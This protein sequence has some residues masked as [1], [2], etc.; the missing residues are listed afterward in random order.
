MATMSDAA[1]RLPKVTVA[2][3]A[4]NRGDKLAF[5]L[6]KVAEF[7]YPE[8]RLE[9]V[10][11]DNASQ[12]GTAEMVRERFA[13]VNLIVNER[14]TG[15]AGWN[16]A[17]ER[18]TGEWFL[19]LDDDCYLERD[20]LRRA[21]DAARGVQA[22]LVSFTVAST[23][24]GQAFTDLSRTGLL[25]FWGCSVLISRRALD[26]VGGF[27]D[28]L[29]VHAHEAEWAIRF[30][31]AGLRHLHMPEI[32]AVHM[33]ALPQLVASVRTLAIRNLAYT[34][35][36]HLQ[37]RDALVALAGL[38][39]NAAIETLRQPGLWPSLISVWQGFA[40][41]WAVRRPVRPAVSRLYR[42]NVLEF[43]FGL[44]L[45]PRLRHVAVHRGAPGTEFFNVY[46]NARSRLYP[47]ES[48]ALRVPR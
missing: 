8:D 15:I 22:D 35:A 29:F 3:L 23:E 28:W 25:A 10:V 39:S 37:P 33:K 48:A 18:G 45:R 27:D 9:V 36:K 24:P 11:V 21:V 7:D 13:H 1:N 42:R 17:F 6:S 46:W 20:A 12:D 19:V 32:E 31:D 2:I 4:Y 38:L 16:R 14:N 47:R 40:A 34:A 5:N 30:M 43:G 44:H 26:A 41:G